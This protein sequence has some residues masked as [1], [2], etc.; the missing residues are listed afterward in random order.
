MSP[1][2]IDLLFKVGPRGFLPTRGHASD[3]GLDLYVSE[4]VMITPGQTAEVPTDV[5]VGLPL[6]LWGY[7]VGR[8]SASRRHGLEV[9][10]GVIDP[11]YTGELYARVKN[12]N[13]HPVIV[14][15]GERVSQLVP[16]FRPS[17]RVRQ[18]DQLPE[19]E[20]GSNGFGS[21]GV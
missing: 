9:I 15:R 5:A 6:E 21:T 12:N 17:V 3:A 4:D 13:D 19:G 11:G 10:E 18:V 16:Q 1:N 14:C 7:V 8:S 2:E 20:R